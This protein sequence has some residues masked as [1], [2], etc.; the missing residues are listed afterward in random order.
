MAIF[1][2]KERDI[3][4]F[5]TLLFYCKSIFNYGIKY[6]MSNLDAQIELLETTGNQIPPEE[7]QARRLALPGVY[8]DIDG[9]SV[10]ALYDSLIVPAIPSMLAPSAEVHEAL[11]A[12]RPG[13]T[14]EHE[15]NAFIEKILSR[16]GLLVG[17]SGYGTGTGPTRKYEYKAERDGIEAL[18]DHFKQA[19]ISI[20][21]IIDGA[22]GYGVPG[23][24]GALAEQKGLPTTGFAPL[25]SLRGA[26]MRRDYAVVGNKFG[27]EAKAL[28]GSPDVLVV[29]GGGP[30]ALKEIEAAQ[31]MGTLVVAATLRDDYPENSVAHLLQRMANTKT[32]KKVGKPVICKTV[33]QLLDVFDGLDDGRLQATRD[34][35]AEHLAKILAPVP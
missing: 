2:P 4:H 21:S 5:T 10:Q 28:G 29:M 14:T 1:S 8:L 31:D 18:F 24:S 23:L 3:Q 34:Q 25:E 32:A 26:A 20:G 6:T 15:P 22:T 19:G 11:E 35:R 7:R 12:V 30:N 27:D 33:D 9:E 13:R 17:F 16:R